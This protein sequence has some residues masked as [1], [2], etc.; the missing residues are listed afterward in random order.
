[1]KNKM[2]KVYERTV[3]N[4]EMALISAKSELE[5]QLVKKIVAKK[6]GNI[7]VDIALT[8]LIGLGLAYVFRDRLTE[9]F[10]IIFDKIE[11]EV[12]LW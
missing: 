9:I 12:N 8:A 1:M 6:E 11:I 3:N 7:W 10:G 4:V 5:N 2:M